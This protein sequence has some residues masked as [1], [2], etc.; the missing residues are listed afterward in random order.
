MARSPDLVGLT[1]LALLSVKP[2]HPYEMHRF[3]L[4]THKDYVTGLPRSL[5][6]AVDRLARDE[7]IVP[8][9]TSREGR[10]PERTVYELSDEGRAELTTRLRRLLTEPGQ[11][12]RGF[13]A[14]VSLMGCLPVREVERALLTR[15][16]AL[17]SAVFSCDAHMKGL[18]ESGLPRLLM[19][20][21]ECERA[22]RHAELEWVRSVLEGL[23][24]GQLAWSEQLKLDLL[25]ETDEKDPAV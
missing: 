1:V 20:E 8:F 17:E 24:S 11:D 5:Y 14:A 3:I 16:A 22:L 2:S 23:G 12:T 10:R 25:G 15:V 4:D 9:E 21:L 19:L 7:L 13:L 6:H 18:Q